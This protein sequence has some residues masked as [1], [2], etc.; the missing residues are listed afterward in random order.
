MYLCNC[1]GLTQKQVR[2]ALE[3][4]PRDV[5]AVYRYHGCRPQCGRC[6][7]EVREM[8]DKARESEAA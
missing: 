7:P 2:Q 3:K 6:V 1:N 4:R 5:E 8:L